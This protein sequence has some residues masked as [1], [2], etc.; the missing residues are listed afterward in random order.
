MDTKS[1]DRV[2]FLISILI[3]LFALLLRCFGVFGI[4]N[5]IGQI[6]SLY[7]FL[8]LLIGSISGVEM[9]VSWESL[10][11]IFYLIYFFTVLDDEPT[12]LPKK[13]VR[14]KIDRCFEMALG[15]I[16][17]SCFLVLQS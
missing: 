7:L 6:S 5:L 3:T 10:I 15:L 17:L 11:K 1:V 14:G 8:R 2:S 9:P 16:S 12:G 4:I 13:K